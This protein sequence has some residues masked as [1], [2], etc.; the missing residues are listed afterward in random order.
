MSRVM[1]ETLF[2]R[3]AHNGFVRGFIDLVAC[4]SGTEFFEGC[5]LSVQHRLETPFC[6]RAGLSDNQGSF[7]LARVAS[8]FYSGFRDKNISSTN[9]VLRVD[10]VGN[11]RVGAHLTSEAYNHWRQRYFHLDVRL[12][13]FLDHSSKCIVA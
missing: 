13:E 5:V 8:H 1:S 6:P 4:Y 2:E 11:R 7:K 12:S 10:R 3:G 9:F